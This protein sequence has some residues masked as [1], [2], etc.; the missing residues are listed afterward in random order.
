MRF[1]RVGLGLFV[2]IRGFV[3]A[4]FL[5]RGPEFTDGAMPGSLDAGFVAAENVEVGWEVATDEAMKKV[6]AHGTAVA[7][8]ELAHSVHVEVPGL[9]ADRWY[10]YR[11]Q[12]DGEI[13]P[14]GRA[15][16]GHGEHRHDPERVWPR[17]RRSSKR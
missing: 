11:F 4:A 5:L 12:T 1:V 17:W 10:F 6:V 9:Q 8:P 16:P 2:Q 7:S 13:S 15:R 14:T 3:G